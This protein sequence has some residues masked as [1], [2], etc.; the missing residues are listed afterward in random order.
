[1]VEPLVEALSMAIEKGDI[2]A[3]DDFKIHGSVN[4]LVDQTKTVLH[5]IEVK[6]HIIAAFKSITKEGPISGLPMRGVKFNIMDVILADDPAN[7]GANQMV[8]TTR[9]AINASILLANP[10][11][12]ESIHSATIRIP[13]TAS[14]T[15]SDIITKRETVLQ[16]AIKG[17]GSVQ[18]VHDH[19]KPL[20]GDPL[21]PES[22]VRNLTV[23]LRQEKGLPTEI[24][25]VETYLD[26]A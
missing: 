2:R 14:N 21:D 24:P 4:L 20:E 12:L 23:E 8:E 15:A 5:L 11:L 22:Q 9:R 25:S 6:P 13:E 19:W 18:L 10:V 16:T 26:K 1:M 3:D 7:M 17:Q